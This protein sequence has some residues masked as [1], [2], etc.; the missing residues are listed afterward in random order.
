MSRST[1]YTDAKRRVATAEEAVA[2]Q[3]RVVD[4]LL[5]ENQK[6]ITEAETHL[7]ELVQALEVAV[8]QLHT[9]ESQAAE[10]IEAEAEP[11]API[12]TGPWI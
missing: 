1:A 4:D 5:T 8:A 10:G 12:K 6:D 3:Q 9:I 7:L 11:R 2:M